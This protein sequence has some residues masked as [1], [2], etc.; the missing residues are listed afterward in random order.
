M[1]CNM[2][3]GYIT[4]LMSFVVSATDYMSQYNVFCELNVLGCSF[5]LCT[6]PYKCI[7]Y[8]TLF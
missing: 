6:L 4:F 2:L 3:P 5:K 1:H 7:V 8:T